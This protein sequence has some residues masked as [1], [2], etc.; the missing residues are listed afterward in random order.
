MSNTRIKTTSAATAA[1]E[2]VDMPRRQPRLAKIPFLKIFVPP[3]ALAP[4]LTGTESAATDESH[5]PLDVTPFSLPG[6]RLRS[7]PSAIAGGGTS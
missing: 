7:S 5:A 1:V 2:N 4:A 6:S 3:E